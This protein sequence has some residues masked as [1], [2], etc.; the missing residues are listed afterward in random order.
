MGDLYKKHNK[1]N[2][3]RKRAIL[4]LLDRCTLRKSYFICACFKNS[5]GGFFFS[6]RFYCCLHVYISGYIK[7]CI[8]C[9]EAVSA[10]LCCTFHGFGLVFASSFQMKKNTYLSLKYF[11]IWIGSNCSKS[12]NLTVLSGG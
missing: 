1:L 4:M 8:K 6:L 3:K 10:S 7:A 2:L 12:C 11:T 9:Y 5:P